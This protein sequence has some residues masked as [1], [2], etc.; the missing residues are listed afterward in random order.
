VWAQRL[1]F[2]SRPRPRKTW[3]VEATRD[4]P[5]PGGEPLW[6]VSFHPCEFR[7]NTN[8]ADTYE[9][10][11]LPGTTERFAALWAGCKR[12]G[13]LDKSS[14]WVIPGS[15]LLRHFLEGLSAE[16]NIESAPATCQSG[17]P[18]G[19]WEQKHLVDGPRP[20]EDDDEDSLPDVACGLSVATPAG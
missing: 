4:C 20:I 9:N 15:R 6:R 19:R 16:T 2:S 18:P 3:C 5:A 17:S 12:V 11:R 1:C 7:L 14:P 8:P 10:R 13:A